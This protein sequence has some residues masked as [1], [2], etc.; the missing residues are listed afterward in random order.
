MRLRSRI[1]AGVRLAGVRALQQ[2]VHVA[3]LHA[4][5]LGDPQPWNSGCIG[6][7]H[8]LAPLLPSFAL[9]REKTVDLLF[10]LGLLFASVL[11][12]LLDP[13]DLGPAGTKLKDFL[14]LAHGEA[15]L[16]RRHR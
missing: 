7:Q 9:L 3:A 11:Q 8:R 12:L 1:V 4:N 10:E 6:S 5:F 16:A 14:G 13:F 15:S 2:L